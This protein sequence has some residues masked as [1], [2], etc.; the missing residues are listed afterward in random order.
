[1]SYHL[2]VISDPRALAAITPAWEGLVANACEANPFYEP[3][4][5]LPALQAQGAADFRCVLA[6]DGRALAGLFPFERRRRYRGL[7]VTTLASWRHSAYLLCTPLVRADTAVECLK[8]LLAW[9]G[10]ASLLEL[11]YLRADGP[12]AAALARALRTSR[13]AFATIGRFSRPLLC[14]AANAEAYLAR[15]SPHLR[16]DLRRKQR[17]IAEQPGYAEV[18]RGP[19]GDFEAE[20]ERFI[21]LEASGWKG[22]AGGAFAGSEQS[23][24]FGRAVLGEAARRGRLHMVGLDCGGK[25]VARRFSLLAGEGAFAFKTAYDESYARY[26]PGVLAEVMRIRE[27]HRLPQQ[28]MDS[29]TDPA[30]PTANR[31]WCERREIETLA[32]AAGAWGEFWLSMLP[33]LRWTARRLAP[34]PSA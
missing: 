2:E 14:K 4:I 16:K 7:P 18:A 28:W 11:R 33:I 12:F 29:Y 6:W 20:I 24:R 31:M 3:W 34:Q 5:L 15:L 10:D 32:I 8:A 25:P 27:F 13:A 22:A 1:M 23:L 17:R 21:A 19:G 30:N 26:S 9:R